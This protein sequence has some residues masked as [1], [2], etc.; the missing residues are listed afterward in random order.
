MSFKFPMESPPLG[1]THRMFGLNLANHVRG[2]VVHVHRS[3]LFG[4]LMFWGVGFWFH[5]LM[6]V[7]DLVCLLN[8]SVYNVVMTSYS[9]PFH[10]LIQACGKLMWPCVYG[11]VGA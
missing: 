11:I 2:E 9:K 1:Y 7:L 3:S 10:V 5:A 6:R 4:I 8:W